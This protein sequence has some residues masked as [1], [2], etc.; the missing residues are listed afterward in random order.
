VGLFRGTPLLL[1]I[2]FVYFALPLLLGVRLGAMTSAVLALSLNAAAYVC[3]IMRAA[4]ESIDR[5]Q[6]EAARSLGM[7]HGQAMWRVILPQTYRRLIPP[8][9]NEL[10]ALSKDTSLVMVIALPELLYET[11]RIAASY[12]RPWEVY[13]WSA[14][15]YLI[16]VLVLS[17]LAARLER[18]LARREA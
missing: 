15:G 6:M 18:R 12:L 8:L 13:A 10:A 1:Q 3:E 2:L 16:V 11:Q 4:I 5:G 17:A 14:V 7:S 9:V